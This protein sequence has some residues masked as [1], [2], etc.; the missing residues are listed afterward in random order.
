MTWP[1]GRR[2][3][4]PLTTMELPLA[5]AGAQVAGMLLARIGGAPA[6][7]MQKVLPVRAV[8]RHSVAPPP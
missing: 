7:D 2:S 3:G 4:V 5:E 6:D 1:R 8:E